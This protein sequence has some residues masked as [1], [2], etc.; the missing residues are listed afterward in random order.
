LFTRTAP[1]AASPAALTWALQRSNAACALCV[2]QQAS[3]FLRS[4]RQKKMWR[5]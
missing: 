4:F 1:G 5:W 3:P 2:A